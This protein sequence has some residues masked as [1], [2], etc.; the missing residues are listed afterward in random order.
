MAG[1]RTRNSVLGPIDRV[2]GFGFGGVKGVIIVVMAFSVLVLGY[3]TVW[4]PTGRPTWMTTGR[5]YSFVSAAADAMVDLISERHKR[6]EGEAEA[7][8]EG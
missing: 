6:L 2:L 8:A 1:R 4:G 5:T 3:D 7:P